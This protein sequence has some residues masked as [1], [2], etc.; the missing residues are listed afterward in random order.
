MDK[1][2][3]LRYSKDEIE[4]LKLFLNNGP[5]VLIALRNHFLQLPLSPEE[6]EYFKIMSED[7]EYLLRKGI[8]P[9]LVVDV[10]LG[11][12]ATGY[13]LLGEKFKNLVNPEAT[14]IDVEAN[15]IVIDYLNQQFALLRE[16]KTPD[17]L[18]HEL[19]LRA[20]AMSDR[21]RLTRVI[22]Y[23]NILSAVEFR[24]YLLKGLVEE[25]KETEEEKKKREELNST[26]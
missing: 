7:V 5:N 2:Q 11:Q 26:E 20:M 10:P 22:A 6:A 21:E 14:I 16:D 24:I 25:D 17:L 4:L 12:E 13:N 3:V 8:L 18:L 23:N 15:D 9:T 19:P 1:D